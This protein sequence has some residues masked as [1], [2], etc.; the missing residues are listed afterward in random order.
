MCHI[1]TYTGQ[2]PKIIQDIYIEIYGVPATGE[3]LT[4]LKRELMQ[5]VWLLLLDNVLMYCY[6]HGLLVLCG[7]AILRRLFPCFN[8]HSANYLEK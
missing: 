4:F 8:I 5:E 1:L 2:L 3:I 7:N 6:V